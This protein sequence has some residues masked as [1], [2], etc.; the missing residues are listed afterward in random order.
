MWKRCTVKLLV[1]GSPWIVR[2]MHSLSRNF[3]FEQRV[4][5]WFQRFTLT[6]LASWTTNMNAV[7]ATLGESGIFIANA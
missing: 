5:Q 7:I 4:G 6:T 3:L 1:S 2:I